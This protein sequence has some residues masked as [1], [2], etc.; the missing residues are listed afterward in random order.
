MQL[1]GGFVGKLWLRRN[2]YIQV[3]FLITVLR[4][5]ENLLIFGLSI[6]ESS[7]MLNIHLVDI[8]D[9]VELEH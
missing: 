9:F 5:A 6:I 8:F 1:C 3:F 4:S 2:F 7:L